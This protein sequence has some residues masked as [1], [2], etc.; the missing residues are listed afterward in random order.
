M[1]DSTRRQEQ[2][3]EH[4]PQAGQA[5]GARACMRLSSGGAWALSYASLWG[6]L[7]GAGTGH[8]RLDE[9]R[10][11][12]LF[13]LHDHVHVP[14]VALSALPVEGR[15]ELQE[16]GEASVSIVVR[17]RL[18]EVDA[19]LPLLDGVTLAAVPAAA[20]EEGSEQ[21]REGGVGVGGVGVGW[22]GGGRWGRSGSV[23]GSRK[24]LGLLLLARL[25]R[26]LGQERLPVTRK[27]F[28]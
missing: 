11:Q 10:R 16:L 19:V 26:L 18:Q 25:G 8:N 7:W 28:S 15:D 27:T 4:G 20:F 13:A 6:L 3:Q 5:G 23:E 22:R 9:V 17:A 1:C 21:D 24:P 12:R 2:E 14:L